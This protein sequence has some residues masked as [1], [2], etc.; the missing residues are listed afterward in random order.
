M[1]K[2]MGYNYQELRKETSI[3]KSIPFNSE[4]KRMSTIINFEGKKIVLL[5]GAS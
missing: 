2:K 4:R 1:L 5:K 3:I